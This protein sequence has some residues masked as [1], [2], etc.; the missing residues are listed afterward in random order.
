M[1]SNTDGRFCCYDYK[2]SD[3]KYDDQ[4]WR[5]EFEDYMVVSVN[6]DV[7]SGKKVTEP[8][9][10][11]GKLTNDNTGGGGADQTRTFAIDHTVSN[12]SSFTYELGFQVEVGVSFEAGCPGVGSGKIESKLTNSHKQ[13]IKKKN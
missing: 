4:W 10:V 6:F 1:I 13:K 5:C 12:S 11:I 2:K 3:A 8:P 7:D 9:L